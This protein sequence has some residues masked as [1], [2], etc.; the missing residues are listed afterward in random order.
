MG[1]KVK[2]NIMK[3]YLFVVLVSQVLGSPFGPGFGHHGYGYPLHG[4]KR[5]L[6]AEMK[7][8]CSIKYEKE[9]TT[10]TK[11]FTKITG[12]EK[13]DC[14]EIEVCK[15][16]YGPV[17]PY[18]YHKRS[19]QPHGYAVPECEKEMKEVC[20]KV[21][22]KEEVSKEF[23]LC[24]PAPKEECEEREIKVPTLNCEEKED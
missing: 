22:V 24:R 9:C 8:F 5:E 1:T 10:E 11:T 17:G 20:K 14:K 13:G 4:C 16:G 3:I 19:A 12:F 7:K 23:E 18:G 2:A 6:K 15:F 21:P